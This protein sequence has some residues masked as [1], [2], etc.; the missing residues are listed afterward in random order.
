MINSKY[1]ESFRLYLAVYG[2]R[3][4][5][6]TCALPQNIEVLC[7][8]IEGELKQNSLSLGRLSKPDK[9]YKVS[10]LKI[11]DVFLTLKKIEVEVDK[12]IQTTKKKNV[13]TNLEITKEQLGK[14]SECLMAL[15]Y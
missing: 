13:V 6:D 10:I 11:T 7:R 3:T 15:K 12:K 9:K 14:I 4:I 8:S 1:K 2:L 5:F